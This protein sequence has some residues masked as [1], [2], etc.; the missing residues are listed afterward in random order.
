M[1]LG[2]SGLRRYELPEGARG[3]V[4]NGNLLPADQPVEFFW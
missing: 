2:A 3:L 4:E 1:F